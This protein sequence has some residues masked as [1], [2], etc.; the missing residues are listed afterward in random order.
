M[1]LEVVMRTEIFDDAVATVVLAIQVTV[2][3]GC[4]NLEYARGIIDSQAKTVRTRGYSRADLISA[5]QQ[6]LN[7]QGVQL[8]ASANTPLLG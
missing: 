6:E 1:P 3:N 4:A 8:L 5:V 7:T 2:A